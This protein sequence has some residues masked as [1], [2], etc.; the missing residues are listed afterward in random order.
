MPAQQWALVV[1]QGV[2]NWADTV[3]TVLSC[4]YTFV[5]AQQHVAPLRTTNP[6]TQSAGIGIVLYY[7]FI[8]FMVLLF[9]LA[10]LLAVPNLILM[11][12]GG[13]L[14]SQ[15]FTQVDQLALFTIG[16]LGE[17][18]DVCADAL[19]GDTVELQCPPGAAIGTV[20]AY[21]GLP[22]GSCGCPSAQ[23]PGRDGGECPGNTDGT[24]CSPPGSFCHLDVA[25][26][27]STPGGEFR[28]G[29][30]CAQALQDA[31]PDFQWLSV[32]LP[33]HCSARAAQAVVR[34]VCLGQ[35]SCTVPATRNNITWTPGDLSDFEC[36]VGATVL[37]DGRCAMSLD[38]TGDLESCVWPNTTLASP[39]LFDVDTFDQAAPSAQTYA[40]KF[41]DGTFRHRQSRPNATELAALGAIAVFP[42][43]NLV[44]MFAPEL[45]QPGQHR[46]LVVAQCFDTQVNVLGEAFSKQDVGIFIGLFDV[47]LTIVFLL[48]FF[49]LGE[50]E[51]TEIRDFADISASDYSIFMHKLPK[52]SDVNSLEPQLRAHFSAIAHNTPQVDKKLENTA[53]RYASAPQPAPSRTLV[54]P[55]LMHP[56]VLLQIADVNFAL[57]N[58]EVVGLL[59][60]R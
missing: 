11:Y 28:A 12:S 9:S 22:S 40:V 17:G 4:N 32:V 54:P 43:S 46:L 47:V 44:Q 39:D 60:K 21:Y 16:N 45:P 8:K 27:V 6:P 53:V 26:E 42:V 24:E 50:T 5:A 29:S 3:R 13:K 14:S 7:R 31:R 2:P 48:G 51:R 36:P 55:Q 57:D 34:G 23:Q 19:D 37:S 33:Q 25:R 1:C 49:L 59:V 58:T 52:H 18:L 20:E 30:C 56:L 15:L 41:P 35:E 38:S 10:S